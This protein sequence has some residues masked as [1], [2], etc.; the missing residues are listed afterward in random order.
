MI[1]FIKAKDKGH[2]ENLLSLKTHTRTHTHTQTHTAIVATL[3]GPVCGIMTTEIQ[4]SLCSA[5]FARHSLI[6]IITGKPSFWFDHKQMFFLKTFDT[7]IH[8]LMF[9]PEHYFATF[10]CVCVVLCFLSHSTTVKCVVLWMNLSKCMMV[11]AGA[12]ADSA[13]GEEEDGWDGCSRGEEWRSAG[14]VQRPLCF[15]LSTGLFVFI[16]N[17]IF[18]FINTKSF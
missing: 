10:A 2:N 17:F 8:K 16:R 1:L 7:F 15:P 13:G 12:P 6:K 4:S 11:F 5:N 9:I 14:S 3:W 18:I